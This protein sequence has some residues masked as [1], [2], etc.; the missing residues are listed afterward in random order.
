MWENT[1]QNNSE[2]RYFLSSDPEFKCPETK[3]SGVRSPIVPT[4]HQG[5]SFSSLSIETSSFHLEVKVT[6]ILS[7]FIEFLKSFDKSSIPKVLRMLKMVFENRLTKLSRC[8]LKISKVVELRILKS[9]FFHSPITDRKKEFP[10]KI[11]LALENIY[12]INFIS[13]EGKLAVV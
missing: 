6:L 11:C 7:L 12:E 9:R 2:Y 1:D 8:F 3:R 4:T 13:G 5:S 10:K